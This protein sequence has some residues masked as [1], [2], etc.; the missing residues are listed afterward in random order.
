MKILFYHEDEFWNNELNKD[1][2][3][4]T[5]KVFR[6]INK[7]LKPFRLFHLRY[8]LPLKSIWY[9]DLPNFEDYDIVVVSANEYTPEYVNHIEGK[10]RNAALRKIFWYW[11]PVKHAYRP[12]II[13]NDWEL[14]CFDLANCIDYKLRYNTQYYFESLVAKYSDDSSNGDYDVFFVGLDK[15]RL[16]L[17]LELKDG[18]ENVG[19]KTD[20]HIVD[21]K[22]TSLNPIYK[23]KI[24]YDEVLK[25]IKKSKA[26][27]DIVQSDQN[28][29]TLRAMESLFFERKLITNNKDIIRYKFYSRDNI[30]ILGKNDISELDK[31]IKLPYDSSVN[32]YKGYYDF[33]SWLNRMINN[34]EVDRAF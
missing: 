18:M 32:I 7:Y 13:P 27:L 5:K 2:R 16:S 11:N 6:D 30:F 12:E 29:L 4:V 34:E 9:N 14:W 21:E 1:S 25:K 24:S 3:I 31:F 15:G 26:I 8:D 23:Q 10:I 19:L 33:S 20:F 28:G 17:L 22:K